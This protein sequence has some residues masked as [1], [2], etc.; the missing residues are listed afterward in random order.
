MEPIVIHFIRVEN[1]LLETKDRGD[2]KAAV[3]LCL[4]L[5]TENEPD[6]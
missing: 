5:K 6:N 4:V 3:G 1:Y 2:F